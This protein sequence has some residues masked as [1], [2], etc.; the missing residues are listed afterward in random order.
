MYFKN[1]DITDNSSI[2]S[3][4]ILSF[5]GDLCEK[6]ITE[7]KNHLVCLCY[8]KGLFHPLQENIKFCKCLNTYDEKLVRKA[9]TLVIRKKQK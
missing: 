2:N 8:G 9:L 3:P 1:A 5:V 4:D 7:V 6:Y